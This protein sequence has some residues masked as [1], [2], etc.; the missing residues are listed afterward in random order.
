[1]IITY[2]FHVGA[3][4]MLN[5]VM[6]ATRGA[7][8]AF[9]GVSRHV[10]TS[11][12]KL[13]ANNVEVGVGCGVGLAVKPVV[14]NQIQSCFVDVMTKMM[15]KIG[16][17]PSLAFSQGA[18]PQSL[19][20][21][22]STVNTN[23]SS[24]GSMM[25][26]ATKSTDQ[27][28]QGQPEPQP[29]QIGSDFENN[30]LRGTAVG[31]AFGSRTEKVISN[32]LQNPLLKG[33]GGGLDEAVGRL[34][35]E[36][37]MLQMVLKH[38]QIIEKLVEE[39]ERLRRI[40]MEDLKIPSRK[41]EASSSGTLPIAKGNNDGGI[42]M[43]DQVMSATK[44]ATDAFSGVGN[45]FKKM[46]STTIPGMVGYGVGF[47]HGYGLGRSSKQLQSRLVE[48]MTK[49]IGL[50][51]G[52][53]FGWGALPMPEPSKSAQSKVPTNQISAESKMQLATKSA[54]QISQGMQ[55]ATKSVDQI[56]QGSMTQLATK[57]A[58]QI[59]QGLAGLVQPENKLLQTV[60]KQRQIIDELV[61]E[62]EKL[63]RI[64]QGKDLKMPSSKLEASSSDSNIQTFPSSEVQDKITAGVSRPPGDADGTLSTSKA[65]NQGISPTSK[66]EN[67]VAGRVRVRDGSSNLIPVPVLDFWLSGKTRTQTHTR[68]T[69]ILPVKVGTDSG[70]YPQVRVFLPCLLGRVTFM[71]YGEVGGK[72]GWVAG[73]ICGGGRGAGE[74]KKLL[75]QESLLP[76]FHQALFAPKLSF[77]SS[78]RNVALISRVPST[79][80]SW[81]C[82]PLIAKP[83][84]A[85]RADSNVEG[86]G[87][88]T[89][90]VPSYNVDEV[91]EG[92]GE[93]VSDSE[94]PKS[95]RKPRVK[96]GDVMGILNQRA[97]EASEK[98][99]PTPDIRT[100]DIVEIKLEVPENKRRLSIYKGIVISKQN[101]GIHTTIR[102]R[103]II[104]GTGV[105][106]VFPVYSPNIKEI[107]VV[108]HRKVR[109]ARLYYLRDKLPRFS[110]FK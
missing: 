48:P 99:R 1:M 21:A 4:P 84:F 89:E 42:P 28:S 44:G 93:Q 43:L 2:S 78:S 101:A 107:R 54:D 41:L 17:S 10:N 30:P 67:D 13:G 16:L 71:I 103:R 53:P 92:E 87:E 5:Q 35:S 29:V 105:E 12:R 38:Q 46:G 50:I 26:L 27:V 25:Q 59:S 58:S 77:P 61:E 8:D 15:T 66:E 95:P 98:Q 60:M 18:F 9:S 75:N 72:V 109:R 94:A 45:L 55:Q 82:T 110:T 39:N 7:T 74:D 37:T 96:L 11:L 19:Q 100:G 88:A 63:C 90:D 33:E 68:S 76:I 51:P 52:L 3:I 79:P 64:L 73:D 83:S 14:L 36:R 23:Q 56:S 81:R 47:S 49:M 106:I 80:I 86:A 34:Q 108:S 57:S 20:S 6:S 62:N 104:A 65:E 102:I 69:R 32:F 70:G 24:A 97:I 31:S 40:L 91:S 22:V 85:V